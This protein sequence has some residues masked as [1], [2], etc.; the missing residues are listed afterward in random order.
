MATVHCRTMTTVKTNL[1]KYNSAMLVILLLYMIYY[2][3][4][5]SQITFKCIISEFLLIFRTLQRR[6]RYGIQ[7][8]LH[9][10]IL[11][12]VFHYKAKENKLYRI[13]STLK[14]NIT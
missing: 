6:C 4:S 1:M 2:N 12:L 13:Y 3:N 9:Y 10:K 14:S 5:V 8:L 11:I 7:F